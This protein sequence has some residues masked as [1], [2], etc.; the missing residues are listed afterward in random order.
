MGGTSTLL[1]LMVGG[2]KRGEGCEDM[3]IM[4]GFLHVQG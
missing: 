3:V 1:G 4:E 2:T